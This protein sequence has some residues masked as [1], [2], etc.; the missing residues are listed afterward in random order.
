MSTPNIYLDHAASTPLREEVLEEMLPYFRYAGNPSSV[1]G[2][3][4]EARVAIEKARRTVAT[5]L[6]VSPAEIFFTGGGTE[7]DN[8]ALRGAAQKYNIKRAITSPI[9]HHAVLHTLEWMK[10]AGQLDELIML[11]TDNC[12]YVDLAHLESL[13]KDQ[14]ATLVS[15]MHG[16]NEIGNLTDIEQVARICQEHKAVYHSDTVQTAG[17]YS[18]DLSSFPVHFTAGSA[19]KFHGPRGTGF[20]YVRHDAQAEPL[21]HGGAQERNMRGGT[22]NL[23]GIVGLAKAL[24]LSLHD[25]EKDRKH[26]LSLK[27]RMA[28]KLT[29][30]LPDISL[31]GGCNQFE[32]SLYT[33]LNVCFPP[34]ESNEMLLF[35]LDI[36][37]ISASAGSACSSGSSI[38]SHVLQAIGTPEGTA[39]VRFSFGRDNTT[40]EIDRAVESV[41][42]IYTH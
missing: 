23:A 4:R 10:K 1:H 7:A 40:E 16:N 20:M 5:L 30:A 31:N 42:K 8:T 11:K 39:S 37:Q 34:H 22:E 21:I 28:D 2:H 25:L 19:H 29:E 13:L 24:E 17:H 35:N 15:L 18:L 3:G 32:K 9:E 41:K 33:V 14:P 12:G 36:H 6:G 27:K 26:I 38:G